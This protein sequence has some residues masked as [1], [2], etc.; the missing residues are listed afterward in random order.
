M[1]RGDPVALGAA[2]REAVLAG[3]P[4]GQAEAVGAAAVVQAVPVQVGRRRCA[5][6]TAS[7]GAR[8][9]SS[10]SS[11]LA[12]ARRRGT[13]PRRLVRRRGLARAHAASRGSATS[14]R[15]QRRA[16]R[17]G[18]QQ[19]APAGA[20]APCSQG[21]PAPPD[22]HGSA[23]ARW[24]ASRRPPC[25]WVALGRAPPVPAAPDRTPW[26]ST[27]ARARATVARSSRRATGFGRNATTLPTPRPAAATAGPA[28]EHRTTGR[29]AAAG[30][31]PAPGPPPGRPAPAAARRA[32]P[33]PGAPGGPAPGPRRP[34]S[35]GGRCSRRAPPRAGR[36]PAAASATTSRALI[37]AA[38]SHRPR[39]GRPAWRACACS[40]RRGRRR[41]GSSGRGLPLAAHRPVRP[42]RPAVVRPAFTRVAGCVAVVM[43]ARHPAPARGVRPALARVAGCVAVATTARHPA[44]PRREGGGCPGG[45]ARPRPG[46]AGGPADAAPVAPGRAGPRVRARQHGR[47][48]DTG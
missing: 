18:Q 10:T 5:A 7:R 43:T 44:P 40:I 29:A 42:P 6:S 46:G 36:G 25:A 28:P 38:G 13:P 16:P 3:Q 47:R 21:P 45:A 15:L 14:G 48:V 33:G 24:C 35:P 17:L 37:P 23:G 2:Q 34:A 32:R 4:Q 9:S 22:R 20:G 41:G 11:G 26:G 8:T 27:A 30:R 12:R 39:P 1:R 31:P 19:G